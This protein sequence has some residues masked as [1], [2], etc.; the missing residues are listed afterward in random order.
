M[1]T[2]DMMDEKGK[3]ELSKGPDDGTGERVA[4]GR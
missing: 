1:Y 2:P 3:L 4:S